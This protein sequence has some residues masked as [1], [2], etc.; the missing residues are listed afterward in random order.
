MKPRLEQRACYRRGD[1]DGR[2]RAELQSP[3]RGSEHWRRRRLCWTA[4]E[5]PSSLLG[6]AQGLRA[7]SMGGPGS[8]RARLKLQSSSQRLALNNPR[9]HD[10]GPAQQHQQRR[11]WAP[12]AAQGAARRPR[13]P[14]SGAPEQPPRASSRGS[15]QQQG[16]ARWTWRPATR[17]S[18]GHHGQAGVLR[19]RRGGLQAA[20]RAAASEQITATRAVRCVRCVLAARGR[21]SAARWM[22]RA[23]SCWAFPPASFARIRW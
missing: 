10:A 20:S 18:S 23:R 3:R 7:R 5:L 4:S 2:S 17:G 12:G 21:A 13:W 6:L 14:L 22:L 15:N 16:A 9:P 1:G 11:Q 8:S 19:R